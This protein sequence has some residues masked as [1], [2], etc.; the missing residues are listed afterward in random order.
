MEDLMKLCSFEGISGFEFEIGK[1]VRSVFEQYC[2]FTDT[3]I[4]GNVV[5]VVGKGRGRKI[6]IEAHL[7]EIGLMVKNIEEKGFIRFAKIGGINPDT[8]PAAEVLIHGKE[9]VFGVI[10]AKPPH[11]QTEDESKKNYKI[12]E[13]YIDTG[14]S[15]EE[16]ADKIQIGD[17]ITFVSKPTRLLNEKMASKSIDNRMGVWCLIEC[18]KRLRGK[19]LPYELIF[20]A[21]VQEEVGLRGAKVASYS[22]NPDAAIVID[23]T[24][25]ISP[26][27]DNSGSAFPLGS[28]VAIGVGPNLHPKLSNALIDTAK[29]HDIPHVIEVCA[30][31][32]G[33]DAWAIQITKK[34]IPCGLLSVPLRYM[35]TQVETVSMSDIEAVVSTVCSAIEEG[36]VC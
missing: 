3:D 19:D 26:Y 14:F 20:L 15:R 17:A 16:L 27:T 21:A 25:G 1:Y 10:G 9:K 24:H 35:H 18:A 7:D 13:M 4:L 28:G 5:G 29:K 31:N 2:D 32:S 6:M 36:M 33:T 34:G 11:L 8:L 12:D 23:V 30:G 22:I